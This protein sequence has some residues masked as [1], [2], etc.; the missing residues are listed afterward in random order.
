[1]LHPQI[2][3]DFA[4]LGLH[5]EL[6]SI[7]GFALRWY[8]LAY[9]AGILLAWAYVARLLRAPAAPMTG[10]DA[11]ALVTWAT[12]GIILGGRAAYVLFYD[13]PKFAEHPIDILKLWE[14][15]MSFHGGAFGVGLA[16]ILY[17]R[18]RGL[19]WLRIADYIA[20]SAPIGLFLGRLANFVNGEL[21]GRPTGASFG[22]VFPGAGDLPRWPSQLM[23]AGL[24]G[25][26]LFGILAY[27]FWRTRARLYP[28]RL[29]GL[30]LLG[31]G[32]VR[33]T[34]EYFREPDAQLMWLQRSTGFSMGQYLC[35]P[36]IVGGAWLMASAPGRRVPVVP[37][38]GLEPQQ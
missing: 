9:L 12:L 23:E 29:T 21:W 31:Y 26:L 11:D 6:F 35:L 36:M 30:F 34:V 27:A 5:R 17:A 18:S 22:I 38:A 20:C 25:V 10:E 8:S 37:T 16:I 19:S 7:G 13:L 3:L 33:F 4:S 2:A 1:M 28:G 32:I 14:G 24:E 15:G